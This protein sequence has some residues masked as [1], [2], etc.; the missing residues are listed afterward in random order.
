MAI[1]VRESGGRNMGGRKCFLFTILRLHILLSFA[2][3]ALPW[4][5]AYHDMSFKG[6]CKCEQ[7]L[8]VK[9]KGLLPSPIS[10]AARSVGVV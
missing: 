4:K 1:G 10:L 2:S 9:Q 5:W 7:T 6:H 3:P 8:R